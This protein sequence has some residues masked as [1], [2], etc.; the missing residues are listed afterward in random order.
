M[1]EKEALE[2]IMDRADIY[3]SWQ[4]HISDTHYN[5]GPNCMDWEEA[6]RKAKETRWELEQIVKVVLFRFRQKEGKN[7]TVRNR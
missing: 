2:K 1:T 6:Q 7:E 3:A 4:Q 5:G